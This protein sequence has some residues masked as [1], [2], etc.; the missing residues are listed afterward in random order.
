[1]NYTWGYDGKY[2][3]IDGGKVTLGVE[4][5][6]PMG[7]VAAVYEKGRNKFL[8]DIDQYMGDDRSTPVITMDIYIDFNTKSSYVN[9]RSLVTAPREVRGVC[10]P[11]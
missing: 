7:I 6:D 8:F 10:I 1:M 11:Q 2:F 4:E 3:F 9:Y 5:T